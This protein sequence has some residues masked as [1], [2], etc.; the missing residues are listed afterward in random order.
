MES[1]LHRRSQAQRSV[2]DAAMYRAKRAGR[3]RYDVFSPS[4]WDGPA[5]SAWA[6][7]TS[8]RCLGTPSGFPSVLRNTYV[9][10]QRAIGVASRLHAYCATMVAR[11]SVGTVT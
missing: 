6:P 1:G 11:V 9:V 8:R 10:W 4:A 7:M 5:N 2:A 3:A